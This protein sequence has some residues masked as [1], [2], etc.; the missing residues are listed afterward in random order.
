MWH[1][2]EA[3]NL[4]SHIH[5]IA[6][7]K[8]GNYKMLQD[9]ISDLISQP[10]D[11]TKPLWQVH[12]ID[13]YNGGSVVL[14]RLHH[15]IG[16]GIALIKVVFSLTGS[17]KE[18]SLLLNSPE[19]LTIKQKHTLKED[20]N[21][22]LQSGKGLW[23]EAQELIKHPE[24]LK[25]SLSESWKVTKELGRLFFGESVQDTIYKGKLSCNKKS[26]WSEPLPLNIIKQIGKKHNATVNDILLALITGALRRH[27]LRHKQTLEKC[28]RVVVPVNIRKPEEEIRV[29]NKIGMLSIE[30]PVNIKETSKRIEYIREKTE[31][32]KHSIEP[33]L[34]YNLMHILADVIPA[35]LE[36]KF[37]DFIGT[38]IAGV[39]T[40]VPGPKNAIYLA[41]NK[42]NDIM[43]WVP[44]TSPLGIGVSIISYNNKVCLGVVTDVNLVKEPD[45]I[46]SGYYK[47]F[48][49]MKKSLTEK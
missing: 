16:D 43:F 30:L 47:E 25:D 6:L 17:T 33:V 41:G 14:W 32:L 35:T 15:A 9:V 12:L 5:Y 31:L 28:I 29:H 8:K 34:I 20:V 39:V 1:V 40:N 13:N 19:K 2:D 44:Q 21:D 11:E 23:H 46:I 38:I 24:H 18:E 27:L 7:P 3:F 45:E 48:E 42:V 26:A 37:S 22:I 36:Q 4:A 10:L 49:A